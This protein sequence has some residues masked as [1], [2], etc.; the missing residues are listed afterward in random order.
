MQLDVKTNIGTTN[1]FQVM[2][3]AYTYCVLIG[4]QRQTAIVPG[5]LVD[6]KARLI[7]YTHDHLV[8]RFIHSEAQY[9]K[10]ANHIGNRCRGK[11]FNRIFHLS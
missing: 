11:N 5:Y 7:G 4:I 3:H 1:T 10:T 9:I 8:T 2:L 6:A